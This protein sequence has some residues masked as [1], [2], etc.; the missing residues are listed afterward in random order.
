MLGDHCVKTKSAGQG[1]C[2][3]S[4]AEAELYAMVEGVSQANGLFSL[5]KEVGFQ[6]L[7]TEDLIVVLLK[8]LH[9]GKDLV[10]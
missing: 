5:A 9:V 1:A 8:V 10:K 6:E 4:S 3:L 2:A 7:S